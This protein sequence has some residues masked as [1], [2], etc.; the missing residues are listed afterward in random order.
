MDE[1]L[2]ARQAP[3]SNTALVSTVSAP[4][5]PTVP[6]NSAPTSTNTGTSLVSSSVSPTSS[7]LETSSTSG[8][9]GLTSSSATSSSATSTSATSIS[10]TSSSVT[11][12]I[13]TS[14]TST[15]TVHPSSSG[16]TGGGLAGAIVGSIAGTFILTL[17]GAFLFFRR[18]RQNR[19]RAETVRS[20]S[21]TLPD[22]TKGLGQIYPQPILF[23]KTSAQATQ[24]SNS[25]ALGSQFLNLSPYIPQ[26]ADDG[27]VCM[28]TQTLFDQASLHIDNYYSPNPPRLRLT[29]DAVAS[30][31][32]YDSAFLPAPLAMMLSKSRAQRAVITHVLVRT[33]LQAIQPGHQGECL[34]PASY[35]SG[36]K[37]HP[38]DDRAIFAWR[39]L[40]AYLQKRDHSAQD[41]T[42]IV[43]PE[44]AI[45]SLAENFSGS[46]APYSDPQFSD[47]DR[48]GHLTSVVRAASNLGIWLFAQPCAIDFRWEC[49]STTPDQVVVLPAV[50]K[51][52][53]EQ[54]QRLLP[55]Q[56][57]VEETTTRC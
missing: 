22:T 27:T 19:S 29:Q 15:P 38:N 30:I 52:S 2:W 20:T 23:S 53:D 49:A 21:T 44:D 8:S 4:G 3:V 45:R 25:V 9:S 17:L 28:R 34:L 37:T 1:M 55:P 6:G 33:L 46:F 41:T 16:L 54:G 56:V 14:P 35:A 40:T 5:A 50:V 36:P 42:A 7:T 12:S 24:P 18:G 51:V 47:S 31:D 26:P 13:A 43:P 57:L 10:V 39:I 32:R 11:S 48:V